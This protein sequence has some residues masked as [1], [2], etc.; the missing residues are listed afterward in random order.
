MI[1]L[2]RQRSYAGIQG[3]HQFPISF[4][5][6]RGFEMA[7][8]DK[9]SDK[10]VSLD[11]KIDCTAV[12]IDGTWSIRG[13]LDDISEAGAKFSAFGM[14]DERIRRDEFFLV[15]TSDGK[16]SRRCTI[17]WENSRSFGLRF[18]SSR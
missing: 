8:R 14:T 11:H 10:R 15:L 7:R 12:A 5:N 6:T 13:R 1:Q 16:V 17:V 2:K 9:R 4:E 18:V 3:L